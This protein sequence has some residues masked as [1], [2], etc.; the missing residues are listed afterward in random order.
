MPYNLSTSKRSESAYVWVCLTPSSWPDAPFF[1]RVGWH[2]FGCFTLWV[3]AASVRPWPASEWGNE[4]QFWWPRA[5][6]DIEGLLRPYWKGQKAFYLASNVR[7]SSLGV[8]RPSGQHPSPRN[9]RNGHIPFCSG[10]GRLPR[11]PSLIES[12]KKRIFFPK[13]FF[14]PKNIILLNGRKCKKSELWKEMPPLLAIQV[15]HPSVRKVASSLTNR[16][17]ETSCCLLIMNS[18]SP[19]LFVF[20]FFNSSRFLS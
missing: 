1:A 13:Q 15:N 10:W 17:D 19:Q 4:P 16:S 9:T 11:Y 5:S 18:L 8:I 6:T 20:F 2:F 7:A 12:K 14:P 3:W